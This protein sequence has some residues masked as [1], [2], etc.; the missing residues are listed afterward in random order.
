MAAIQESDVKERA[1]TESSRQARRPRA[2]RGLGLVELI[3]ALAISAML[4]ASVAMAFRAS[5]QTAEE[6]QKISAITQMAR[7]ILNRMMTECRQA[8]D[9]DDGLVTH[10]PYGAA[11]TTSDPNAF[12][13]WFETTHVGIAPPNPIPVGQPSGLEYEF[14]N[15]RLIYRQT[16]GGTVTPYELIGPSDGMTITRF[17]LYLHR[18][19]PDKND[20]YFDASPSKD[21]TIEIIAE[22]TLEIEGNSFSVTASTNPRRE[23]EW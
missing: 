14:T 21:R 8:D 18:E 7:V 4:L 13:R 5:V 12:Y 23:M 9:V 11:D 16:I 10:V 22:M 2:R 3:L 20:L 6:N 17:Q 15:G 1:Q 19:D